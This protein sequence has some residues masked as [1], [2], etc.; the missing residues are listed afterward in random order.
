MSHS[1][2]PPQ[3][4]TGPL[5]AVVSCT[6]VVQFVIGEGFGTAAELEKRHEIEGL[7]HAALKE[8]GLGECD[9]G[10]QGAG[11]AEVFL[12]VSEIGRAA[13]VIEEVCKG[14][15]PSWIVAWLDEA[16][17]KLEVIVPSNGGPFTF[18]GWDAPS[19]CN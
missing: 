9:G 16:N 15:L 13:E 7:L 12:F 1:D 2:K 17:E 14:L 5:V 18:W 4:Q 6:L 8:K 3:A 11:S 10:Q 19:G